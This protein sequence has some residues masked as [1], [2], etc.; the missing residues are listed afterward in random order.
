MSPTGSGEVTRVQISTVSRRGLLLGFR[1]APKSLSG[2][3]FILYWAGVLERSDTPPPPTLFISL[4]ISSILSKILRLIAATS[5]LSD[6]S[7]C[8]T[9]DRVFLEGIISGLRGR[10]LVLGEVVGLMTGVIGEMGRVGLL[11]ET[12]D[13]LRV[14]V[15]EGVI[16]E[17]GGDRDLFTGDIVRRS[18]GRWMGDIGR[19]EWLYDGGSAPDVAEKLWLKLGDLVRLLTGDLGRK[20][21]CRRTGQGKFLYFLMMRS[22]S[23]F[24]W[25]MINK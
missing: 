19:N 8:F 22:P 7:L 12:G 21:V 1:P 24:G 15:L 25:D 11:P 2:L 16:R 9:G 5:G 3:C 14:G 4:L 6:L 13:L 20:S 10:L 17:A 18:G 23:L